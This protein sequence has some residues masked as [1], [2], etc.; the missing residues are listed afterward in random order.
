VVGNVVVGL[1]PG[2]GQVADARDTLAAIGN[3]VKDPAS[4]KNWAMLGMAVVGWFPGVGDL[5]KGA[6]KVGKKA[7]HEA[8]EQGTEA[9]P[10]LMKKN[11]TVAAAAELDASVSP[12]IVQVTAKELAAL[13]MKKNA[14]A[15][16]AFELNRRTG[17]ESAGFEIRYLRSEVGVKTPWKMRYPDAAVYYKGQL[18]EYLE[19][20]ASSTARYGYRQMLKDEWIRKGGGPITSV[21]RPP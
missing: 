15:G 8:V 14:A 13:Q 18:V 10:N 1:V 20:K 3:L 21:I 4:G 2:V 19:F 6:G 12:E 9:A 7:L 17:Y 11:T 5:I 16:A